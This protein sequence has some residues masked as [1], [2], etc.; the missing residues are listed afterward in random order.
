MIVKGSHIVHHIILSSGD[1]EL[2]QLRRRLRETEA[3]M[4]R[5]VEQMAKVPLKMQVCEGPLLIHCI[6]MAALLRIA[7]FLIFA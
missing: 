1:I 3:A 5:I 4:E 7:F 6:H 2:D